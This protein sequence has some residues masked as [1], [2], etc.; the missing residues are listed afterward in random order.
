M[1]NRGTIRSLIATRRTRCAPYGMI[2]PRFGRRG[3]QF[4]RRS[5]RS[6]VRSSVFADCSSVLESCSSAQ[7][8]RSSGPDDSS[9]RRDGN[10]STLAAAP[11]AWATAPRLK[12]AAPPFCAPLLR[13]GRHS[14]VFQSRSS[15]FLNAATDLQAAAPEKFATDINNSPMKHLNPQPK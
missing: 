14:S 7:K 12:K 10:S 6:H 5:T 11:L 2:F 4:E 15:D 1:W 3:C 13:I 9:S 8:S